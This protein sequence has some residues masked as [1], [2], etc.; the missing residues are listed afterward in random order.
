MTPPRAG[1]TTVAIWIVIW[2]I[3]YAAISWSPWTRRGIAAERAGLANPVRP[4]ESALRA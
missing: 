1:P 2:L 4:E 3:E